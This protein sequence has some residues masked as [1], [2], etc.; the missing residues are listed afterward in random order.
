MSCIRSC[1]CC[2]SA[3]LLSYD[4]DKYATNWLIEETE[5][6]IR[7]APIYDNEDAFNYTK[8]KLNQKNRFSSSTTP[9][10]YDYNQLEAINIFLSISSS[11]YSNL[12]YN[13]YEKLLDNF[14]KIIK[15]VEIQIGV[16]IPLTKKLT[17]T[18]GFYKNM[19]QI[20]NH[21]EQYKTSKNK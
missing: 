3:S 8:D 7:L 21:L 9:E 13:M 12:F 6:D 19:E 1:G 2:S 4:T 17:I 15:N 16:S 18:N 14:D 10:T 5:D 11:E 20:R